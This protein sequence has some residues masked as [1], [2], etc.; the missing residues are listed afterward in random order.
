MKN[1]L[2]ILSL[3]CGS[4]QAQQTKQDGFRIEGHITGVPEKSRVFLI[5]ANKPTDTL[6]RGIVKGGVFVLTGHVVEPN[7]FELNF[8]S[9][10]KKTTLFI[11]NDVVNIKGDVENLSS[12]QVSGSSSENDFISFQQIFTPYFSHLNQ[13]SQMANSPDAAVKKDSIETVYQ[14]VV[15]SIQMKV[16]SFLQ[17]KKSSYVSPFLLVIVNQLSDDVFLLERRYLSLSPNVKESMFGKYLKEQIDNGKIGAVGSDAMDFTQTDTSGLP[18]SLSSYKGKYVLVDFWA[19]WCKPCRMENP[20]VLAAYDR[21]KSKNF[22]V[23]GVSLDRSRDA[24]VKAIQDDR[25]SWAQVS[26]LKFWN[27]AVAMQYKIQQI[28]QNFLID[29]NGKIV[30]KN[31]R[32]AELDS[33]LCALLGC[34]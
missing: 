8:L 30:G 4:L 27:N 24:W 34:N 16:D 33:K 15:M 20:N 13:I 31:L 25:L 29:P 32:G 26:D 11:G 12:I 3:I 22:T 21:F 2:I 9:A 18:V 5:D 14:S 23:L 28:P 19:S 17:Q 6:S 10:K 7:L 1:Y